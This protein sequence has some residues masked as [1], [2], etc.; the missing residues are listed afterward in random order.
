[1]ADLIA[2]APRHLR[3]Q[4]L[5]ADAFAPFGS[6]AMIDAAGGRLVNQDR[7]RRIPGIADLRHDEAA[8]RPVLDI[9]HIAPSLLPFTLTCFER[10]VLSP[11]IFIPIRCKRLLIAVAPDRG[12]G[13]PDASRGLA[14]ICDDR[15]IIRYHAGVWHSPLVALDDAATLTM[16][17]WEAGDARDCQE[18]DLAVSIEVV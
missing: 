7:A 1:M 3:A 2:K 9:Y 13:Q 6:L 14:F 15:V 11:Q 16:M 8:A 18:A 10:H 5:T 4:P 17:M 12:D